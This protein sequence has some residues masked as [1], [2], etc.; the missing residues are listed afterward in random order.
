MNDY[1]PEEQNLAYK[2]ADALNDHK[3]I[4]WHLSLV[5]KYELWS[6]RKE[7]EEALAVP[8]NEVRKSRAAIYNSRVKAY[9]VE[10]SARD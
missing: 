3:S 8:D 4:Q 5:R 1:S 9:G 6:L 2:F 10:K 7:L